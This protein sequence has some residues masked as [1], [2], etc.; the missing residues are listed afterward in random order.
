MT[1]GHGEGGD[2][3]AAEIVLRLRE[4]DDRLKLICALNTLEYAERVGV[5]CTVIRDRTCG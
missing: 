4:R 1:T 2:L 5:P 3:V